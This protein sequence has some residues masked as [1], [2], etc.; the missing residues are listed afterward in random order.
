MVDPL[1]QPGDLELIKQKLDY[2]AFNHY[3]RSRVR[4]D[5]GHPFEAMALP[6]PDGVPVT[7]MGW[8]IAPDALRDVILRRQGAL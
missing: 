1:V 7:E 6:P 4:R 3:T 5:P 2:F 8:E